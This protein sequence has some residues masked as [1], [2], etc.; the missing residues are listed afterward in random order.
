VRYMTGGFL[1]RLNRLTQQLEPELAT[2]WKLSNDGRTISF[3]LREGL[4]FSDGTTFSADDVAYT[5]QRLMDPNL[6]STT[7]DAF[8]SGM[9]SCRRKSQVPTRSP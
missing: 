4:H 2:S 1:M 6:H 7:G 9:A 5:L 8:R 3:Q